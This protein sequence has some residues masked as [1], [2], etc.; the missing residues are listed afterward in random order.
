M[1]RWNWLLLVTLLLLHFQAYSYYRDL[2]K[3]DPKTYDPTF[4]FPVEIRIREIVEIPK[5]APPIFLRDLLM[6]EWHHVCFVSSFMEE[7]DPGLAG[8]TLPLTSADRWFIVVLRKGG[9]YDAH[10]FYDDEIWRF[11]RHGIEDFTACYN[12]IAVFIEYV[13]KPWIMI[14]PRTLHIKPQGWSGDA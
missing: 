7:D 10:I 6:E 12:S 11:E 3:E 2:M 4:W 1:R 9:D 14:A 8:V 5:G 13:E